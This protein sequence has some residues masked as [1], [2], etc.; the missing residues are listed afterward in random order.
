[1]PDSSYDPNFALADPS[2]ESDGYFGASLSALHLLGRSKGYRL[3]GA[4]GPN[5]NAFFMRDDVGV[6]DFPAVNVAECLSSDYAKHQRATHRPKIK[7]LT[8]VGVT[9]TVCSGPAATS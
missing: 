5:T 7:G 1:M 9:E 6:N 8:C 3:I 2:P 4:N